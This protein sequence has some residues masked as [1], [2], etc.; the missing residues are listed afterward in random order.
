MTLSSSSSSQLTSKWS[1]REDQVN[2]L[3]GWYGWYEATNQDGSIKSTTTSERVNAIA[4]PS[5]PSSAP[6]PSPNRPIHNAPIIATSSFLIP[7]KGR[8]PTGRVY[9]SDRKGVF[10]HWKARNLFRSTCRTIA[11]QATNIFTN[12]VT[13]QLEAES[14]RDE[15]LVQGKITH[16]QFDK[17]TEE[18]EIREWAK[19]W[20]A[21]PKKAV[22]AIIKFHAIT[23]IMRFYEYVGAN[24]LQFSAKTMDK[25]T[26]DPFESA[27]RKNERQVTSGSTSRSEI[28]V[29]MFYTCF[30]SNAVSLM[31]DG[32]LQHC[33]VMYGYYTFYRQQQRNRSLILKD[34]SG[35]DNATESKTA[36]KKRIRILETITAV[37]D[38]HVSK[39][40]SS[41]E[42]EAKKPVTAEEE[43]SMSE[44]LSREDYSAIMYSFLRKSVKITS[45]RAIALLTLSLGGAIGT[46][47]KPG[48]GTLFGMNLGEAAASGF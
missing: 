15:L 25:L 36:E 6:S 12:Y 45:Q 48:W 18:W 17:E 33:I 11:I 44:S 9:G 43:I 7:L 21:F 19:R 40:F 30:W 27:K 13:D 35:T 2:D 14:A 37:F 34:E 47:M 4:Q 46:M 3:L 31:A 26:K 5:T 16:E 41:D 23:F 20:K 24:L 39:H 10:D 22:S 8:S 1:K 38:K 42:D 29:G 28:G 32:T